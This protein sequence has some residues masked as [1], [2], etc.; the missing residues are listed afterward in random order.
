[1]RFVNELFMKS[2]V[3]IIYLVPVGIVME[4]KCFRGQGNIFTNKIIII[5]IIIKFTD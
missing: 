2:P 4:L 3:I 1:M 5:I